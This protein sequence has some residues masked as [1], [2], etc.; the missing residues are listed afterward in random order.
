MHPSEMSKV[1]PMFILEKGSHT[2]NPSIGDYR[3]AL[4]II[5]DFKVCGN[6][7]HGCGKVFRNEDVERTIMYGQT[8]YWCKDCYK[9]IKDD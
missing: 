6:G 1:L 9:G 7:G 8:Y 3:K 2:M 5:R 4:E